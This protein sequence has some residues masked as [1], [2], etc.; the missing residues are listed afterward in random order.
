VAEVDQHTP[1]RSAGRNGSSG[2]KLSLAVLLVV[3]AG[4]APIAA[5][6]SIFRSTGINIHHD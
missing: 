6:H 1:F 5:A 3:A 2:R 4:G